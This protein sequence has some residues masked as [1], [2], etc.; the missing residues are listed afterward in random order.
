LNNPT[1]PSKTG[2]LRKGDLI[3]VTVMI[4]IA[5][6]LIFVRPSHTPG[7]NATVTVD[8]NYYGSWELSTD[9]DIT[10]PG[11]SGTNTL[12][13]RKGSASITDAD[14]P[15]KL[16]VHHSPISVSG[17]RIICLPNRV[18]VSVDSKNNSPGTDAVSQ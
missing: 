6:L 8:G 5:S 10:I 18:I 11:F 4:L 17:E 1:T 3:L 7:T 13:I 16:C 2:F 15:D 12:H 9:I 14:C